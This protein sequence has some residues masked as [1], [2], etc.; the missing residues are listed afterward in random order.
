MTQK[1]HNYIVMRHGESTAN[2]KHIMITDPSVDGIEYGLTEKG[3]KQCKESGD[4]LRKWMIDNGF[5][6][7]NTFIYY[8]DFQRAKETASIVFDSIFD[9]TGYKPNY[10]SHFISSKL[11]RARNYGDLNGLSGMDIIP[12]FAEVTK[13]DKID[14]NHNKYN[15]ESFNNALNRTKQFVINMEEKAMQNNENRK[16]IIM[17]SHAM[18]SQALQTW[19]HN[20]NKV[21]EPMSNGEFR[22]LSRLIQNA[23]KL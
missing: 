2:V 21:P 22:D 20:N 18:A 15:V 11:L 16:L 10:K 19:F 1:R 17:V 12:K 6:M 3:R 5:T 9:E 4:K 13:Y 14:P 8:S 23:S 7:S